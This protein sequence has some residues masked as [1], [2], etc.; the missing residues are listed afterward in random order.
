MSPNTAAI[1]MALIQYTEPDAH[2]AQTSGQAMLGQ[3][4]T[5]Q[6]Q[7]PYPNTQGN[8]YGMMGTGVALASTDPQGQVSLKLVSWAS[9]TAIRLQQRN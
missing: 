8:G 9:L 4:E 3:N 1:W 6:L 7:M 2:M 5:G